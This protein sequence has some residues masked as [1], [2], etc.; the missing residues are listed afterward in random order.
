MDR[1]YVIF[2]G[3]N[4]TD[5]W[6]GPP[7]PTDPERAKMTAYE[8]GVR[9]P[10]IVRGPGIE[11][12]TRVPYMAHAVDLF[13]TI[14]ELAAGDG[15]SVIPAD[16]PIDSVSLVPYLHG[17]ADEELREWNHSSVVI[18]ALRNSRALRNSE[19]KLIIDN[20]NE[21]LYHIAEDPAELH[22]LD[23]ENLTETER[24]HYQALQAQLEELN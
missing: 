16:R 13:A 19:Y 14:L 24:T 1:T 4:G 15:E 2:L 22:A 21:E 12:G 3:D 7:A 5:R 6:S 8:G 10:L 18:G 23:L 9:V 20:G 17:I 11:A